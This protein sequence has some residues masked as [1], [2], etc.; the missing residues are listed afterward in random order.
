[1]ESLYG[2]EL[3]SANETEYMLKEGKDRADVL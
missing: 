1:M 2:Q 3:P